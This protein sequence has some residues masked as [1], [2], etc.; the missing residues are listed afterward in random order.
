VAQ[1]LDPGLKHLLRPRLVALRF[2]KAELGYVRLG[3]R[4]KV[5]DRFIE[6]GVVQLFEQLEKGGLLGANRLLPD[7]V[8]RQERRLREERRHGR[9]RRRRCCPDGMRNLEEWR[10]ES[11]LGG[12]H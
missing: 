2:T 5:G 3:F 8:L 1:R 7:G 10:L 9:R 4:R 12:A 11:L 6:L